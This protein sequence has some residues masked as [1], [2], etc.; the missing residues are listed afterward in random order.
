VPDAAP[1]LSAVV[2]GYR[3]EEALRHVLEELYRELEALGEEFELVVVANYHEGASDRTPEVAAEFAAARPGVR[4]VARPK[5]GAMGWDLRSGLDEARGRFLV[6]IDGDGQNPPAD[7]VRA[8]RALAEGRYD[9][10]KGRRVT[11][12]DGLYRRLLSAAYNLVFAL[13]FGT[14]GIWDINGKPKGLTR[15]A[16]D[17]LELRSDDWFLDAELM[18]AARRQGMRIGEI[19]VEFRESAARPSFVR[20]GAIL[21]F[22]RHMLRY[23]LRGRL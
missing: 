12:H 3:A 11:R 15:S 6:V 17:R 20:P 7:V 18:L 8:Y 14:W 19:P 13:F 9:V 23:R 21:E 1:E 10:V 16:L 5:Q 4:T 2:L 22:A